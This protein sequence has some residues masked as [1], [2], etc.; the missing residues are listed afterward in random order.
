MDGRAG[1]F[2]LRAMS[3]CGW[4]S[5]AS[6]SPSLFISVFLLFLGC[7]ALLLAWFTSGEGCREYLSLSILNHLTSDLSAAG[8]GKRR[9]KPQVRRDETLGGRQP[10]KEDK[11]YLTSNLYCD[12]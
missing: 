11:R 3:L 9:K 1:P 4:L 6:V 12:F 8:R 7:F 5:A 2:C 10:G